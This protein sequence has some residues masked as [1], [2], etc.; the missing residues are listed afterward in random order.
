MNTLEGRQ[1]M[2]WTFMGN[3]RMYQAL[4]DYGDRIS[5]IGLFS[6]K[7]KATGEIY[8]SGVAIS[9]ML[10][11]INKWSHIKWLLTV[12][13]DGS[14]S[15][16][17]A[18][19]D[20]TD[21][22]QDMF[23]SE[24]VRIMKKY[25][26]C[27][28]IDID[29]EKGDGYSTH[30]AS[31]Q[32]FANI[33]NT[34]KGYDSSKHMNICLPGMTSVNGS[35]GGENW[36]VYADL[37]KYCDTASIM[38]YGMA[39][40]GSAPGPVSPRSWLEGIYDYASK[41]MN[42]KKVFLGM[43][44]YGWNWQIYDD[45]ANIGKTYRGT[46]NTYYA[47]QNWMK[48]KY[49]FT[50]DAPPQPF[51]PILSYWDDDN[52]VPW[53]LPQVY[54]YMEGQDATS[55]SQPQIASSYNG[56]KYLTAYSKEQKAEFGTIYVDRGGGTPD[57]YTGVVS[58]SDSMVSLGDE[59]TATYNFTVASAGTYDIAVRLCYPFW[60]T[61]IGVEMCEP[62]CIKYTGGSS[63]TCSN[64]EEAKAVAKRTYEAAVELFAML[65]TEYSLDP[66]ADGV[67]ISHKEG[68]ARGVASNHGDPEHLWTQLGMG[69]TMDGFRKDV[70]AAM[71]TEDTSS[72]TKIM[73]T[74]V[75]T[76]E[77]MAAYI[78]A[79]NPSVAQSVI[80]MIPLYLSEGK[81]EGVRGDIAFAQSCLETG[82]FKFEGTAVTL[83]QNNY[84]GMGVTSK[85]KTGNSFDTAQLGIRAQIQHLK[86]YACADA[87]VN[88]CVD[89]RFKYV[90]RG[91]AEY[92]DWLGQ[93]ENPN[94]KGWA[95]GKGYGG[96]ILTILNAIIGT[97]VEKPVEEKEVWYRVRKTWADAAS[98]KGAYHNL[99]YAKKCADENKGY[100]VF[101][102]SGKVLYSNTAFEPY[103][104][105]VS[106][107]DLNIRK[108]PGT[109][110][111]RTK[112]IPKG[113]YTIVEES[114]GK[115]AT[116]WGKLKSGAGWISL[117]YVKRV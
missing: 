2:V 16:F 95:T 41:V 116:K 93:K 78:K 33:Y 50:G 70:K 74:A 76:A 51:I 45:P 107:S 80:D 84:C 61:H 48:G 106:I 102:E 40:A 58:V 67:I 21:G 88:E 19:R 54:D 13:N 55:R 25:S 65:C 103:L 42:P 8:E 114:D 5:Q 11:Y 39:W 94:G 46:S 69:Y 115:G 37:D 77:Q 52:K 68:H 20:N 101:D 29:L 9:N 43:P 99:E 73:G 91:S 97:K 109:N 23:L 26:W 111:A 28:G 30:K 1:V 15:I 60:D 105:K 6:F 96:K 85:G 56:R 63:F 90:T 117:D 31:T 53:A 98:Q 112:Y 32:M 92:V 87:L 57:K 35:V 17:K 59:G 7:V 36:C 49:N 71:V 100:S 24:I 22:A 89:P 34:V 44:T 64:L 81:A 3:T 75:A 66:T 113:V 38:S 72:Y 4:R 10:T 14:N 47:A 82:N 83:A 12:A 27:D 79:K 110:Y 86:A 62:A 18:L 108:G 104:V